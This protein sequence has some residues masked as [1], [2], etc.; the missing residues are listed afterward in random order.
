M[1]R[2]RSWPAVSQKS[3]M[4]KQLRMTQLTELCFLTTYIQEAKPAHLLRDTEFHLIN[5]K[6]SRVKNSCQSWDF[7]LL[8]SALGCAGIGH[9]QRRSHQ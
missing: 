8:G 3:G 6:H 5:V 1:L 9:Q 2:N 4:Q 7:S